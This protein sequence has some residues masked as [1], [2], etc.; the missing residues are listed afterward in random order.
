MVESVMESFQS[1]SEKSSKYRR[2]TNNSQCEEK[3]DD[4]L[5]FSDDIDSHEDSASKLDL[6][7]KEEAVAGVKS[8][9][10][11]AATTIPSNINGESSSPKVAL[12]D[13]DN[14]VYGLQLDHHDEY[15]HSHKPQILK[16]ETEA[17]ESEPKQDETR[18]V[19]KDDKIALADGTIREAAIG[20]GLSGALNL[21]RDRRTLEEE[22]DVT[23]KKK[24][25]LEMT[26]RGHAAKPKRLLD[27]QE[28]DIRIERTDEFG[29]NLTEKEAYKRF[30]HT[31]HG[32]KS[33]ARKQEKR[34]RKYKREQKLEQDTSSLFAER[35]KET[36]ARLQT[37]YIV[38]SGN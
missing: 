33:G 4:H 17:D 19:I 2:R 29:R 22:D 16:Q 38:L 26:S 6:K 9:A 30:C 28:D 23:D 13:M 7:K 10:L 11:L 20:K 32:K 37:P 14:F 8:I 34:I 12:T 18:M 36:Q 5:V 27:Y 3:D 15:S 31:F 1:R 25:K 35:M 24:R 21:L